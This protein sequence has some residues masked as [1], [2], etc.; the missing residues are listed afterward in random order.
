[1]GRAVRGRMV[2]IIGRG[3]SLKSGCTIG[4]MAQED[5]KK[6][7]VVVGAEVTIPGHSKIETSV[8]SSQKG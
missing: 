2:S 7:I 1:M 8:S 4:A 5:G 3:A 6:E